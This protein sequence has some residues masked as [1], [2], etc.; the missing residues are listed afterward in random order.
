MRLSKNWLLQP[1]VSLDFG[2][3]PN[4]STAIQKYRSKLQSTS[5]SANNSISKF[6]AMNIHAL[7]E[8]MAL[9]AI[10]SESS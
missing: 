4:Y 9:A 1:L 3:V 8:N 10:D 7:I 6:Q 2:S 5:Q